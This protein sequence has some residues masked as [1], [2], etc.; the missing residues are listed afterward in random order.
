[1]DIVLAFVL[2]LA[3]V[4][5]LR[6]RR[7]PNA[8]T[9]GGTCAAL[10]LRVVIDPTLI[11]A[12]LTGAGLG[13]VVALAL[14]ASGV[15]GAG[16]GKLLVAVGAFVGPQGLLIALLGAGVTG[17]VMALAVSW[18]RG[19]LIPVLLNVKSLSLWC[20]TFGRAGAR[21][22]P[23]AAA[24]TVPYGPAIAAGAALAWAMRSVV[25]S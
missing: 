13:L 21:G 3:V 19:V 18:R 20:L 2:S 15:W 16:D 22:E 6:E 14:Y 10:A 25:T 7:I 17:G 9:L 11:A 24:V 12:G 8:L 23:A 5:D 1:M 4:Y